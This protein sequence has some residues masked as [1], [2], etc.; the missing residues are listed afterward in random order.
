MLWLLGPDHEIT[1]VGAMNIFVFMDGKDGKPELVTPSL[2]S[3]VIL[4]GVTRRSII[5]MTQE[6]GEFDV[7]ERKVTMKEVRLSSFAGTG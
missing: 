3:G 4:P 6:W 5:E 2:E 7:S 1:E